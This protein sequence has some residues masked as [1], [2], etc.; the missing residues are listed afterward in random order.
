VGAGWSLAAAHERATGDL[1]VHLPAPLLLTYDDDDTPST[2]ASAASSS[3]SSVPSLPAHVAT[4]LTSPSQPREVPHQVVDA[5]LLALIRSV[6]PE[7]WGMRLGLRLLS[8]RAAGDSAF[9]APYVAHLPDRFVGVPLFFPAAAV[10]ALQYAPVVQQARGRRPSVTTARPARRTLC[11]TQSA[12]TVDD[13]RATPIEE[14]TSLRHQAKGSVRSSCKA[15][16]PDPNPC[17]DSQD[18]AAYERGTAAM[19][20]RERQA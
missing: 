10:A 14:D 9:W 18:R 12:V 15:Q 16:P 7:L 11:V 13:R 2:A 20:R 17:M 3:T 4:D 1:L 6:P 8:Q 19:Q 5:R